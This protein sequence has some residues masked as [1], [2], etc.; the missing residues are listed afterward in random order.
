MKP[1]RPSGNLSRPPQAASLWLTSVSSKLCPCWSSIPLS[2]GTNL[3]LG[4]GRTPS[5]RRPLTPPGYRSFDFLVWWRECA[6]NR[7]LPR[8][9]A[10][11][12]RLLLSRKQATSARQHSTSQ[13]EARPCLRFGASTRLDVGCRRQDLRASPVPWI[14]ENSC[15]TTG[16][17]VSSPARGPH[18]AD[19]VVV[20]ITP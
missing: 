17:P 15:M 18:E 20:G 7:G 12:G 4:R 9:R 2:E 8:T 19:G 14:G 1:A 6:E 5:H 3:L 16:L 13:R 11:C 10:V